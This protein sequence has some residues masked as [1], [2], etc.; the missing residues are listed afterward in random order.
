MPI[1]LNKRR[2]FEDSSSCMSFYVRTNSSKPLRA[3]VDTPCRD[4]L[5]AYYARMILHKLRPEKIYLSFCPRS[6]SRRWM[7]YPRTYRPWWKPHYPPF[8][9]SS[10]IECERVCFL[11]PLLPETM[12][13]GMQLPTL[14]FNAGACSYFQTGPTTTDPPLSVS[15][16]ALGLSTG[17][18]NDGNGSF[19]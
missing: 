16:P 2:P 8:P 19:Q 4:D 12:F 13:Q 1:I 11:L 7:W 5:R 18:S 9:L 10:R 17:R 15:N 6:W 3:L 14:S